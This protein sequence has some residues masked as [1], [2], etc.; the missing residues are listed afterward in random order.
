MQRPCEDEH[1][2]VGANT[3]DE[4]VQTKPKKIYIDAR[5]WEG[6]DLN[7]AV[8]SGKLTADQAFSILKLRHASTKPGPDK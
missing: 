5:E 8:M 3:V 1:N 4:R 2:E 6:R 7:Q